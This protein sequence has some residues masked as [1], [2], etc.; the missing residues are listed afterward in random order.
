[1]WQ[2]KMIDKLFTSYDSWYVA[3]FHS[4]KFFPEFYYS[5]IDPI[6]HSKKELFEISEAGKSFE[7][8]PIRLIKV[9]NGDIKILLWSQMHGDESTATMAIADIVNFLAQS[10]NAPEVKKMLSRVTLLFLPMLNP[11]GAARFQRRTAQNIDM[12]RDALALV[13]PEA[14][15]LKNVQNEYQPD[16]G[17]NLHDQELSTLSGMRE[18]TALAL[19]APAV[20]KEKSDNVV[21]RRAKQLAAFI[22]EIMMQYIPGKIARYDDGFEPRAFGDSIQQCGTSTVLLESGHTP[23]DENKNFV[24]KLNATG[25]LASFFAIASSEY[26]Y[27]D[28]SV[29]ETLPFNSYNAYDVIIRNVLIQ[30]KNGTKTPADLAISYEVDTHTEEPPKL[31]DIGDL[32]NFVGLKEVDAKGKTI[33]EEVLVIENLFEWEKWV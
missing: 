4:R 28:V 27:A 18:I 9:G 7:D 21:R 29:Y 26:E 23:G 16:F 24:R 5:N 17:F 15:I 1:M 6:I 19:L 33:P 25:L 20:D 10:S 12:N 22:A 14:K 32:H 3:G 2:N 11:D 8:R 13:T 30:H 31:W